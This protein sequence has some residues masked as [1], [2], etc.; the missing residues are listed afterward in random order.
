MLTKTSSDM[1]R[2]A[3]PLLVFL[4]CLS[5]QLARVMAQD[6]VVPSNEV[7]V[8]NVG[9]G[10]LMQLSVARAQMSPAA[11]PDTGPCG[12]CLLYTSPSPRD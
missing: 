12:P 3:V 6:I 11:E 1:L 10:V 9:V 2:R 4:A 7:M 5:T 8:L